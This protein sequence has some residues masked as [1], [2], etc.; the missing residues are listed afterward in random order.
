MQ[1]GQTQFMDGNGDLAVSGYWWKLIWWK[2]LNFYEVLQFVGRTWHAGFMRILF[3]GWNNSS[4]VKNMGSSTLF[5]VV[6]GPLVW[7]KEPRGAA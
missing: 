6:C 3:A 7:G 2:Y 4:D 1:P 5:S